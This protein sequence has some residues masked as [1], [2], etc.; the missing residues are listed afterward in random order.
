MIDRFNFIIF[1]FIFYK[2][3]FLILYLKY[4]FFNKP[5]YNIYRKQESS[6][7]L[8]TKC[9]KKN[10]N[11]ITSISIQ[12]NESEMQTLIDAQ[13]KQWVRPPRMIISSKSNICSLQPPKREHLHICSLKPI[14]ETFSLEKT[15]FITVCN[16]IYLL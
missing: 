14:T 4:V 7:V 15:Q 16:C 3:K 1:L 11:S 5:N 13:T 2:N 6:S 12:K 10:Y 8:S 9:A